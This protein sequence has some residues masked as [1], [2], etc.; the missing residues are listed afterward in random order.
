MKALAEQIA[1]LDQAQIYG[2]VAG[3][4][5]LMAEAAGPLHGMSIG[6]RD[7]VDTADRMIPCEVVGFSGSLGFFGSNARHS[8]PSKACGGRAVATGFHGD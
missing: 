4:R 3:V 2:R 6:A 1:E 5:G 8:L 7:S